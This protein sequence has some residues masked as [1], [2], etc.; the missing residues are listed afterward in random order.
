MKTG[1]IIGWSILALVLLIGLS[2]G[3]TAL[4]LLHMKVFEPKRQNI[5]R[6]I[7]ENTQSYVE[8]KRQE[9]MKMYREW[10]AAD[11][12]S[13]P[14]LEK[15]AG[16]TFSNVDDDIFEEPLRTWVHNCKYGIHNSHRKYV[17]RTD[18]VTNPFN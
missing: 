10:N 18:S 9:A 8:G 2:W 4:G 6:E 15:M 11:D 17:P 16:H 1:K 3:G 12:E 14:G 5:E 7:F 13:K